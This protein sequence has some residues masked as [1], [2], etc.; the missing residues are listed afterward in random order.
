MHMY[1]YIAEIGMI[2]QIIYTAVKTNKIDNSNDKKTPPNPKPHNS[3]LLG[4]TFFF[5]PSLHLVALS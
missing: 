1:N 5:F 3:Q 2:L 4:C